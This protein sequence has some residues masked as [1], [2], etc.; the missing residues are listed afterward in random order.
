MNDEIKNI[1]ISEASDQLSS[2][3]SLINDSNRMTPQDALVEKVFLTMHSIKGSSPMF[4]FQHMPLMALPVEKTFA[5]I[6][7]GEINLT[8]ELIYKTHCIIKHLQQVLNNRDDQALVQL[9]ENDEAVVYF[10]NL[11]S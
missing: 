5:K 9:C 1:F 7:K 4:G 10:N 6:R 8:Q 11:C 2:I 3:E